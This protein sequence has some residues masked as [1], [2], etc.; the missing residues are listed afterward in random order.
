VPEMLLA[1]GEN[2]EITEP[3][4]LPGVMELLPADQIKFDE[5][6]SKIERVYQS[7]GFLPIDTPSIERSEVLLAKAGG[8]TE[9][10]IY[11]FKKG[12][13]NICLR[14]D[15][16]VPLA[17]YVA[18]NI[19]N[20]EFP[21]KRYQIGK[22]YRGEKAQKGRYRE[23]YQADIDII[24]KGELSLA[25]DAECPAVIYKIFSELNFGDFVINLNNRKIVSG[26]LA[27]LNLEEKKMDIMR[28]LDKFDKIGESGVIDILKEIALKKA[29]IDT[30][31][32]F[33]KISG[34][35]AEQLKQ[36]KSFKISNEQFA[37]GVSE[38]SQVV[39]LILAQGVPEKNIAI[40]LSIVRG[41][42]YYTGTVF[43]TFLTDYPSIGSVCSG[44]R[45]DNLAEFYTKEKL[46]GVGISIGLTRLFYQLQEK[47]L[48]SSSRLSVSDVLVL[49]M[50]TEFIGAGY[51]VA[52][53]LRD[54]GLN[55]QFY[56]EDKKFK[57]KL[58]YADKLQI[59]YVI[60]IGEDEFKTNSVT[61]K[62]MRTHAQDTINLA[63][64]VNYFK[65]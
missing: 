9:K 46:P 64:L 11:E 32:S 43:E 58:A 62:N 59:P 19:N 50:S 22:V 65:C 38:L 16:T 28:T 42:D 63:G 26:L 52:K 30:L 21:F 29:Q 10:Q 27:S 2:M 55:V 12:D 17:K 44:G 5:I 48:V 1:K 34:S 57:N 33:I 23:F 15:L 6:K 47:A 31:L 49:P 25:C 35:I 7:F 3:K 51:K 14:F 13:N 36:L 37:L 56:A 45:Y 53:I 60:I 61:I 4:S 54:A 41:L 18:A 20:L 39:A 24:G 40:N 8:E